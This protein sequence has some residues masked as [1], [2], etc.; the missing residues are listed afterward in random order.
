MATFLRFSPS[1]MSS[2]RSLSGRG[3]AWRSFALSIATAIGGAADGVAQILTEDHVRTRSSQLR[4]ITRA[5]DRTI[6]F[7]EQLGKK[8]GRI[9]AAGVITEFPIA[10]AGSHPASPLAIT[11]GPDG[12]VWWADF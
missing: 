10:E 4:G 7:T 1:H 6:W 2:S 8:I 11:A 5:A 12:N 9:T 3:R